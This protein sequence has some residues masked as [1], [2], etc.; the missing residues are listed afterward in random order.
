MFIPVII[1]DRELHFLIDTGATISLISRNVINDMHS[2]KVY[3]TRVQ[4]SQAN[5]SEIRV[6][7]E[8]EVDMEIGSTSHRVDVIIADIEQD[9]ILG[10]DFLQSAS[11]RVD[12]ERR[13]VTIRG[14]V[15]SCSAMMDNPR[16]DV[17]HIE[18][19]V[20]QDV[21]Q[22]VPS[23]LKDLYAETT[24]QID[25]KHHTEIAQLLQDYGDV[26]ST[27]DDDIGRTH[28][29][30]HSIHTSC[31][32]PIRQGP[33]RPPMGLKDEID[34]QVQD[35]L[36][37]GIIT[38]SS[39]PWSSPV[40]LVNKKDGSKRFCVDYRL[41]NKNT[42]KDSYPLPRIDESI[43]ALDG[44]K[45]FCTLDLASG[46]WQV[47]LDEDAKPKSAFVV[48]GGLYQF[49]VMPFGLC[50]APSTFERLMETVLTGLHW[51]IL[52]IYLD[53]IIIFGAS[54]EEVVD[55]LKIVLERLRSA[56]LKLK[57][58][59]CHLFQKE[60]LYLG[61]VV[62]EAGVSTDPA[63]IDTIKTWPKPTNVTDV[64]SFL[65]LASYYRRYI[66]GFAH[67][68]RPLHALT[69]KG[70][71]FIWSE[72]CE[73]AFE[74]LK[75]KLMASPI[76]A[77][78]RVGISFVMDTDA[79]QYAIGAVLSQEQDGQERVVAYGSRT[80]SKPEQNYCVTRRELLAIIHFL[81]HFRHYLYGQE[82]Q[83]RTDHGALTWLMKFKNPEGQLARWLEVISQYRLTL[84]HRP[85]RVHMNADGLS[86]RPCS[87]CGRL[88]DICAGKRENDVY[89]D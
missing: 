37:R 28:M 56:N 46:Y 74:V 17:Q 89:L 15:I 26:F 41:L 38:P 72:E 53:D 48:P 23:H 69:Q 27:G 71:E 21:P 50:N 57:P 66:K 24:T 67:T 78:P 60:V 51:K 65:G 83:V 33:R 1:Q 29:I 39:S 8:S 7:G 68:A 42:V 6:H 19:I 3:G 73:N 58:K 86:R 5:G 20:S 87:Q 31:S 63:K 84:V 75:G 30:S 59:K 52:L 11:A 47:P 43:D 88:N 10:M 82:V 13:T 12:C 81:K 77:Y 79:S 32:A 85:G 62:S 45:Y 14:E 54:V 55:R 80:L 9:G 4:L 2:V 22:N 49:E 34:K 61:H 36:E 44:A 64:R 40:V 70:K 18:V 76:L 16:E 35:M 25:E